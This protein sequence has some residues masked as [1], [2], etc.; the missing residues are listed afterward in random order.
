MLE[1]VPTATLASSSEVPG[2]PDD[3]FVLKGIRWK[4]GRA[5]TR[6]S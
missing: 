5:T 2:H 4:A 3:R 6:R 1:R